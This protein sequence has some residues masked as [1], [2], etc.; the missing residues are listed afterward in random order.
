MGD[1]IPVTPGQDIYYTGVIGPTTSASINRRLHVYNSNK[2]WIKQ[3]SYAGS[4]K[5]G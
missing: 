5:Q 3:M 4:L 2:T 1:F